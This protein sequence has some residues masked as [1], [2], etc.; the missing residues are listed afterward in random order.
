MRCGSPARDCST[1]RAGGSDA[2]HE[3]RPGLDGRGAAERGWLTQPLR[4]KRPRK[5]FVCAHGDLFAEGVP[6]E[7]IDRVFAVMALAPQHTFQVLT[8]RPGR[9]RAYIARLESQREG[10]AV[11]PP[12]KN[13]AARS[14][15]Q[16]RP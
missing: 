5:I 6:D 2:G 15:S 1:I 12:A 11:F 10:F 16:R 13:A 3:G 7:W 8:K 14:T 9:M 4:W